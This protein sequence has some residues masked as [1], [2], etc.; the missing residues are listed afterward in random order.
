MKF[1]G[2]LLV[3]SALLVSGCDRR[4]AIQPVAPQSDNER[5]ETLVNFLRVKTQDIGD[6]IENSSDDATIVSAIVQYNETNDVSVIENAVNQAQDADLKK[7]LTI[8]SGAL[9]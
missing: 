8:L 4:N 5:V 2:V 9:K 7:R 6:Y 3:T 1:F